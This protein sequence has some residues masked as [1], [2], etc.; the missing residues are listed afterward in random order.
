MLVCEGR[1][2]GRVLR[3]QTTRRSTVV[4][5]FVNSAVQ[6][7]G[8][9]PADVA[10]R[11]PLPG[12]GAFADADSNTAARP[13]YSLRLIPYCRGPIARFTRARE[14]AGRLGTPR[15]RIPLPDYFVP[16]RGGRHAP[17]LR[18][19]LRAGDDIAMYG[20]KG[21]LPKPPKRVCGPPPGFGA[22]APRPTRL[23]PPPP[24]RAFVDGEPTAAMRDGREALRVRWVAT[25]QSGTW[26]GCMLY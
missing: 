12:I 24:D 7:H 2:G 17:L 23:I 8:G 6:L 18:R 22:S 1:T 5:V 20:G 14:E 4:V 3:I 13:A 15:A 25:D 16:G 10:A 19:E 21:G 11:M 9:V 26:L